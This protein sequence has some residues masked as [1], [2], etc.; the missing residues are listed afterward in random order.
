MAAVPA[1]SVAVNNNLK[2]SFFIIF[3]SQNY[4]A[5]TPFGNKFDQH[6]LPVPA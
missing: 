3:F 6:R 5:Q 4:L 1:S 2:T